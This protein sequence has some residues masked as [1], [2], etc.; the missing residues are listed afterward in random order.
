MLEFIKDLAMKKN[1]MTIDRNI[2][3]DHNDYVYIHGFIW[4]SN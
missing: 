2:S 3:I 1:K 4:K